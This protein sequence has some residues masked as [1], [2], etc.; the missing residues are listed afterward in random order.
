MNIFE[1][2]LALASFEFFSLFNASRNLILVPSK[3]LGFYLFAKFLPVP[4]VASV[5]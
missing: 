4:K 3:R 1:R 2:I 5:L